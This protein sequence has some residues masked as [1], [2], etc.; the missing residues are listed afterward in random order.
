MSSSKFKDP[1]YLCS[2]IVRV[3]DTPGVG[4]IVFVEHILYKYIYHIRYNNGRIK[5][6]NEED[7]YLV[8]KGNTEH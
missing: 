8:N 6:A 3:S 4:V 7:V 1:K 5:K 2:D